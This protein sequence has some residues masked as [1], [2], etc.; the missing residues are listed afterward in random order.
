MILIFNVVAA[1][2]TIGSALKNTKTK[3][4]VRKLF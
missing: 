4:E 2:I 3:F 1:A